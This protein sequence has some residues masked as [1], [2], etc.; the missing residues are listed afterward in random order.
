M[1]D[2]IPDGLRFLGLE[3]GATDR[4]IKRAYAARLKQINADIE[5]ARFAELR[6]AYEQALTW[7]GW[8]L[9]TSPG[10]V[11]P[12]D[13]DRASVDEPGMISDTHDA[14]PE[15][16]QKAVPADVLGTMPS[17]PAEVHQEHRNSD[18]L[19]NPFQPDQPAALATYEITETENVPPPIFL[20]AKMEPNPVDAVAI[21]FEEYRTSMAFVTSDFP[22]SL[23]SLK[24]FLGRGNVSTMAGRDR[25]E[26][27]L[28]GA[29]AERSF[30]ART[31]V[32]F[33][34][35]AQIFNWEDSDI[36][37]LNHIGPAGYRIWQLLTELVL[38]GPVTRQR[39]LLLTEEP[40]PKTALQSIKADERPESISPVLASLFFPEGHI[41][42]WKLARTKAPMLSR[43]RDAAP[44]AFQN[45]S[46]LRGLFYLLLVPVTVCI[47][48]LVLSSVQ[49]K[50]ASQIQASCDQAYGR[51][52]A[53]NWKGLSVAEV[54]L[55]N[56]CAA[57]IPPLLCTD[58]DALIKSIGRAK[59]L[60]NKDYLYSGS[61]FWQHYILL[62]LPDG[63]AFEVAKSM[64]CPDL[65]RFTQQANW[66]GEGDEVAARQLIARLSECPVLPNETPAFLELLKK[67][68]AWPNTTNPRMGISVKQ[69]VNDAQRPELSQ[70]S[71]AQRP[72]S[73]CEAVFDGAFQSRMGTAEYIAVSVRHVQS[74][75]PPKKSPE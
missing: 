61:L 47:M 52:I 69:L 73:A 33:L 28:A 37:R 25:F 18:P 29:I 15:E 65:W 42:A 21:V 50:E 64:D 40:D 63:T 24:E 38:L 9:Q 16:L 22:A 3:L 49:M 12:D 68:D 71:P 46:A 35:G 8:Q 53:T 75:F 14:P 11:L 62:D 30:G 67:T 60:L 10:A 32:V 1:N 6:S 20:S 36:T 13:A 44:N 72:W 59:R 54:G 23:G 58:R 41:K 39:W 19:S 34:A 56:S 4:E 5:P 55:L 31:A 17:A 45:N 27:L 43:L 57:T 48:Y 51:A 2:F 66:L 7:A 70:S 74:I 26:Q